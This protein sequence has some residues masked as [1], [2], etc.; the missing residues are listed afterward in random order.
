VCP[1]EQRGGAA[2]CRPRVTHQGTLAPSVSVNGTNP[3][4]RSGGLPSLPEGADAPPGI[5]L[6]F[7][8]E[9]DGTGND[10]AQG[11]Y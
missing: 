10:A 2:A 6:L 8:R 9:I 5:V 4:E 1:R 11:A 7:L 3:Q